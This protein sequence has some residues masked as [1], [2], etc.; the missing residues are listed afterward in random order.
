MGSGYNEM[1]I[2]Y[3]SQKKHNLLLHFATELRL[4]QFIYNISSKKDTDLH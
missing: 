2:I 1:E 3:L 4:V